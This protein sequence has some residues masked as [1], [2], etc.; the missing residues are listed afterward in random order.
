[1]QLSISSMESPVPWARRQAS[2]ALLLSGSSVKAQLGASRPAAGLSPRNCPEKQT[3][4]NVGASE[5]V[6]EFVTNMKKRHTEDTAPA[7][8]GKHVTQ[9]EVQDCLIVPGDR[10]NAFVYREADG[11]WTGKVIVVML[12]TTSPLVYDVVATMTGATSWEPVEL[13][14]ATQPYVATIIRGRP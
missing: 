5:P 8:S 9:I 11:T 1:M 3:G 13:W 6:I 12:A 4:P 14:L 10:L 7:C 2:Q